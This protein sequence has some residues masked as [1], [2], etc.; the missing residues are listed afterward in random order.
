MFFWYDTHTKNN[1]GDEKNNEK[2]GGHGERYSRNE[3]SEDYN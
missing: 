3:K 1:K 2:F